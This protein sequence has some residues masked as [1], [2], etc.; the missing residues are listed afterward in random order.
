MTMRL[1]GSKGI[2]Q[3]GRQ[4]T[5]TDKQSKRDEISNK[6]QKMCR[7]VGMQPAVIIV[8]KCPGLTAIKRDGDLDLGLFWLNSAGTSRSRIQL[9]L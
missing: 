1:S 4:E 3:L 7:G 9:S 6:M 5:I 8:T 2:W